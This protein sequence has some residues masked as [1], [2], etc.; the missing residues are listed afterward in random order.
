MQET[1]VRFLGQEDPLEKKWQ[2]TPVFLPGESLGQRSLAGYSPRGHKS[3][4]RLSNLTTSTTKRRKHLAK[5]SKGWGTL[6][7]PF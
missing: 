7:V 1:Q 2:P 3:Q 6:S 4:T 5:T